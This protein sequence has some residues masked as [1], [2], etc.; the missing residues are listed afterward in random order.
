MGGTRYHS[1]FERR[2]ML[3]RRSKEA[4]GHGSMVL[5]RSEAAASKFCL[6]RQEQEEMRLDKT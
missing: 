2:G 1:L 5:R 6:E 3:K 4:G